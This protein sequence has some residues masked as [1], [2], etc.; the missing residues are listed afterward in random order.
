MTLVTIGRHDTSFTPW[1]DLLRLD[2][3]RSS[4]HSG[5]ALDLLQL[6][7]FPASHQ[8]RWGAY[9]LLAQYSKA[10]IF[11]SRTFRRYRQSFEFRQI[12]GG[13]HLSFDCRIRRLNG[14]RMV[15]LLVVL[16]K[17]VLV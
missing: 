1:Y 6:F 8:S 11:D 13:W 9:V 4:L 5:N 2:L 3:F 12:R 15:G 16:S 10:L 14:P 17:P 7:E